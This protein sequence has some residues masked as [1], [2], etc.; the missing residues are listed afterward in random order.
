M[1]TIRFGGI[2][3][4]IDTDQIIR[5]LMKVERS[6]VDKLEQSKVSNTWKQEA[7]NDLNKEFANFILDTK[8]DFGLTTTTSTGS[9]INTSVSSITWAKGATSSNESIGTVSSTSSAVAGTY[10]VHVDSLAS[11]YSTASSG[12][13]GSLDKLSTQFGLVNGTDIIDFTIEKVDKMGVASV[14]KNFRYEAA[15]LDDKTIEDIVKD[16]NNYRDVD[17]NDLGVKAV[18][19]SSINRFFLQTKDTGADNGF[20]ITKGVDANTVDFITGG[21]NKLQTNLNSGQDYRGADGSINFAGANNIPI[22]K[23]TATINGITMNLKNNGDFTVTVDTDVD[24]VYDKIK[25]FVDK[26]NSL[27]DSVGS[28]LGEKT[29]R[30]F[31]PLTSEQKETMSESDIKLW[32][33]KAKSGLL[34]NDEIFTRTTQS[35]RSGF[36]DNV[37]NVDGSYKHLTEVGITTEKYSSGSLGGKLVIDDTKLKEAITNDVDGVLELLFKQAD[38]SITDETQKRKESGIVTR[39]Y[40]NM[41]NGMKDVINKAGPGNDSS[42]FRNV[43]SNMLLDFVTKHGSISTIDKD[44]FNIDDSIDD[45]NDYLSSREDSYW[46]RFTAMEKALSQMQSQGDWLMG[47]LGS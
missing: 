34:R 11:N 39:L 24:S 13:L 4:G 20:R 29:Y 22:T 36:Y 40:D 19:D 21:A 10:S 45:M 3:S 44:I 7:Y 1:S 14:S 9:L 35:M 27:I 30:D 31:K 23:N 32:E 12:D 37:D 42:L 16:I 33:E 47:Q 26:Y 8:K 18:Y 17:G 28:K 46:K 6:K 43:Q 25:S 41:M 2:A 15:D 38:S 5:D